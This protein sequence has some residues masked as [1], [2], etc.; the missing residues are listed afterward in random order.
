[1]SVPLFR[2]V[3]LRRDRDEPELPLEAEG[4]QRYVWESAFGDILIEIIDGR[5]YVNGDPV[6]PAAAPSR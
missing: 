1:M 4:V 3:L 5:I 6:T 2:E